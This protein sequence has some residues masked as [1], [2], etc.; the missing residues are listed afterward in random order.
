MNS[1]RLAYCFKLQ[2]EKS[3]TT[4][5][6]QFG[7]EF[8]SI[9]IESCYSVPDHQFELE[10]YEQ[11]G[12]DIEIAPEQTNSTHPPNIIEDVQVKSEPEDEQNMLVELMNLSYE[13]PMNQEEIVYNEVSDYTY[14][15]EIQPDS[16]MESVSDN[17]DAEKYLNEDKQSG[18]G[19]STADS[20]TCTNPEEPGFCTDE[21]LVRF[22]CKICAKQL[23]SA[24][25]LKRHKRIHADARCNFCRRKFVGHRTIKY[26]VKR[27]HPDKYIQYL[28]SGQ[29]KS[30]VKLPLLNIPKCC[31]CNQIFCS[32]EALYR[33]HAECDHKCIECDLVIIRRDCY[34]KHLDKEHGIKI[35]IPYLECPFCQNKFIS[36]RGLNEHITRLHS[37]K[38]ESIDTISASKKVLSPGRRSFIEQSSSTNETLINNQSLS[39]CE[40]IAKFVTVYQGE[41]MY[42]TI[43][44]IKFR[45]RNMTKHLV[46]RHAVIK[47]FKCPFCPLRFHST[48]IRERHLRNDHPNGYKCKTCAICYQ[49]G[50]QYLNHML[51]VHELVI[52]LPSNEEEPDI[53]I[54]DLKFSVEMNSF[55]TKTSFLDQYMTE[56]SATITRCIPCQKNLKKEGLN[57]HLVRFHATEMSF[58]CAFCIRRFT[59]TDYR[60]KHMKISHPT[61]YFCGTCNLQFSRHKMYYEHMSTIHSI[62]TTKPADGEEDDIP[63]HDLIFMAKLTPEYEN[64]QQSDNPFFSK[65][66]K[67]IKMKAE[68]CQ[69]DI[70][71]RKEEFKKKYIPDKIPASS[72]PNPRRNVVSTNVNQLGYSKDEFIE[73]FTLNEGCDKVL[74]I[75]CDQKVARKNYTAH[76]RRIHSTVNPFKCSLCEVDFSDRKSRVKHMYSVHPNDYRCEQCNDQFLTSNL[77]ALHMK[78]V[79]DIHVT[80][81]LVKNKVIDVPT[82]DLLFVQ[83]KRP[84]P[85]IKVV[86]ALPLSNH[87]TECDQEFESPRSYRL[88]MRVHH[89]KVEN[90]LMNIKIEPEADSESCLIE[91]KQE[92]KKFHTCDI[93]NKSFIAVISLN[94]HKK[95]RHNIEPEVEPENNDDVQ[96]VECT[97]TLP[98]KDIKNDIQHNEDMLIVDNPQATKKSYPSFKKKFKNLIQYE[99]EVCDV[100]L[101][102]NDYLQN[103]I[104]IVHPGEYS[105]PFCNRINHFYV[106]M[107]HHIKNIHPESVFDDKNLYDCQKCVAKFFVKEN[108]NIHMNEKHLKKQDVSDNYCVPC[109]ITHINPKKIPAHKRQPRHAKLTEIT[110]SLKLKMN[111]VLMQIKTTPPRRNSTHNQHKQ[112]IRYFINL[113][114]NNNNNTKCI[115]CSNTF[116]NRKGLVRHLKTHDEIRTIDCSICSAKFFFEVTYDKHLKTH[117]ST[118]E[119]D[120]KKNALI[121]CKICQ[122]LFASKKSL[123]TH[124]KL[125]S[126]DENLNFKCGFCGTAHD[127]E[128]ELMI[129][130]QI[131]TDCHKEKVNVVVETDESANEGRYCKIC[132][133]SFNLKIMYNNH[134]RTWHSESN[135]NR[136]ETREEQKRLKEN[137]KNIIKFT[138]CKLCEEVFC[139]TN[140]LDEHLRTKHSYTSNSSDDEGQLMI[141][142]TTPSTS[143][144]E[145]NCDECILSFPCQ[146]YLTNHQK[147]F[148]KTSSKVVCTISEKEETLNV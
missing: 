24:G 54:K 121:S 126:P 26:H 33:H 31:S 136:N 128:D 93:C 27:K 117:K 95:F 23:F 29:T 89:I 10:P 43:C 110:R 11:L 60:S 66:L 91:I 64:Y 124:I 50:Q 7:S 106:D 61:D 90:D 115:I 51:D 88:H 144:T 146:L 58:K 104:K 80:E 6:Q 45:K 32:M 123:M 46:V 21:E 65:K 35:T 74:C 81:S 140:D 111:N 82:Q 73:K 28:L 147:Y 148:C 69:L 9:K 107:I 18:S 114:I 62:I 78:G 34:F 75:P 131:H 53:A 22:T 79:H 13:N 85:K 37:E 92:P 96:I 2:S 133:Q 70:P 41:M 97:E 19:T 67:S 98:E 76:L 68:H 103:H 17:K 42:C 25:S 143:M 39:N 1:V 30:I 141:V 138:K 119:T 108:L 125:H 4:L 52:E 63:F 105:C 16:E 87:C 57:Y 94:A 139:K 48:D 59:R 14:E 109:K 132:K 145:F 56:I 20:G 12:I 72:K 86:E 102:R 3:Y 49:Y 71:L 15:N 129:H 77:Y 127:N 142:E 5:I 113:G 122:N 120:V 100:V 38:Q 83:L 116:S 47:P 55:F 130:F 8:T 36:P 112:Y 118:P 134:H 40:F 44:K 99:C 135:P 84:K 137:E 101:Y